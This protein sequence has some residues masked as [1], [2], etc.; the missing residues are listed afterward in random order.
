MREYEFTVDEALR[1]GISPEIALPTNAQF[2]YS[3]IDFREGRAGL[4]PYI[5]KSN[6][7][8]PT[9]D[10]HYVWP[11]PQYLTGERYNF[12]VVRD[13]I[14]QADI[15]Y[16]ISDDHQTVTFV[17]AVDELHFG[18]GWLMDVA[19]FGEYAIMANGKA[20]VFWNV[21]GNW[22]SHQG[23]P[24]MPLLGTI[25]N[26][27]GQIVGGNVRTT[28]YDCDETFY[29]WSKIGAADFTLEQAVDNEA[30]YR[31]CPY[32]G[33]ILHVRRLGDVVVGYSSKGM[34]ILKPVGERS[35]MSA[36]PSTYGFM[37]VLNVGLLNRG[38]VNGSYKRQVFIGEDL[39]MREITSEGIKELGY[40]WLI[41]DLRSEG[42]DVII[43]YDPTNEDYYVGNSTR[44]F[45][46]S[47]QGM[48]EIT[49]HP[50]GVWR[51][52]NQTYLLPAT[53][54]EGSPE[55]IVWPNDFKFAGQK[56]IQTV[57]LS[58]EGFS[59]AEA[60]VDYKLNGA[61]G[62]HIYRP[63]NNQDIS[64]VVATGNAFRLKVRFSELSEDF[65]LDHIKTR[66][67]MTDMRGVRGVYAPPLR[68]QSQGQ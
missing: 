61:W 11:Y 57:E 60:T 10:M 59:G 49:Q 55:I 26:M 50:S 35:A 51:R 63:S 12:L 25:C 65:R 53:V 47:P 66:Y 33:E 56:T 64:T 41:K 15:I 36:Q 5:Y 9:I 2:L 13:P 22:N 20:M 38:A 23:I 24:T 3:C 37:E 4:E 62:S 6:P 32:G 8:P 67:K 21:L 1:K 17:F 42:E 46:L 19:D 28:W 52:N 45:L 48:T 54:D 31:R 44:T 7:L 43:S 40:K 29:I 30:G 27:K 68:G 39:V 14:Q 34:T 58:G 16:H 18:Q